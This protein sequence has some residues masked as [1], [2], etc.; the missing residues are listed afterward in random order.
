MIHVEHLTKDYKRVK[1][2]EGF[3]G[4]V[5]TLFSAE[6]E[7]TRAVDDIPFILTRAIWLATL[8]EWSR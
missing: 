4:S 5:R 2:R 1:R 3:L 6:Y 8:D 7:T